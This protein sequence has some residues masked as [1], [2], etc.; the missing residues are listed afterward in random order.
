MIKHLH[1]FYFQGLLH[2]LRTHAQESCDGMLP[3]QYEL[4]YNNV[5][6]SNMTTLHAS[7]DLWVLLSLI[8]V[9]YTVIQAIKS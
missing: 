8:V 6:N 3:I 4:C 2:L 7:A 9:A 5:I 1:N